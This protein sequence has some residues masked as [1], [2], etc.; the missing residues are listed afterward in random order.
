MPDQRHFPTGNWATL[1]LPIAPDD[2]IDLARL[3]AE[4]DALLGFGVDGIYSN[5]TAG[6]FFNQTEA[7]FDRIQ[8]LL[9]Q[10]CQSAGMPF[11]IGVSH[12]SPV[13]TLERLRRSLQY[14]PAAFQ[15]ILPDW[16]PPVE[17]EQVRFLKKLA[18]LAETVRLVLYNPPQAKVRLTPAQFGR[19]KAAVPQLVGVKVPG[20]DAGWYAAMRQHMAGLAT[21]VPG[22]FLATGIREGAHGAYSNVACLHPGVA[23]AWANLT[24]TD[25]PAALEWEARIQQFM[26]DQIA[27]L[28]LE[29]RYS[30]PACDKFLSVVGGWATVGSRMRWPYRSIPEVAAGRVREAA[31][32]LI[33][34]FFLRET[35][36]ARTLPT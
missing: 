10:K 1:L 5:G 17:E 23:Q 25:L 20:G 13:L 6:E 31:K 4:I 15:V 27:P 18:G 19:L 24:K 7:E 33:P 30:N 8:A 29:Q 35:G 11:Q 3:E 28:L 32:A 14:E 12:P 34:E 21:F 22:H 16:F 9:A 36:W 2:S 26:G